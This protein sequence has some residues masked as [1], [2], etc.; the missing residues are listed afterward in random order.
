MFVGD[1]VGTTTRSWHGL[2][3]FAF[4][5]CR[6]LFNFW[7]ARLQRIHKI[8]GLATNLSH[9]ILS[10]T[11]AFMGLGGFSGGLGLVLKGKPQENQPGSAPLAP[12]AGPP[13]PPLAI[14]VW[15]F[16]WVFGL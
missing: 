3:L 1:Q 8:M 5:F 2:Y 12:V 9:S 13:F 10:I 6:P 14:S 15:L 16:G 4:W 7:V 11:V